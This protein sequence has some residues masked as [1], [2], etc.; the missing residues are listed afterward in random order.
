MRRSEIEESDRPEDD[1]QGDGASSFPARCEIYIDI[2]LYQGCREVS[3][4]LSCDIVGL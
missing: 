4:A 3:D 1:S 2:R